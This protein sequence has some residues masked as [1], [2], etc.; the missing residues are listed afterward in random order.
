MSETFFSVLTY[1]PLVLHIVLPVEGFLFKKEKNEKKI[2]QIWLLFVCVCVCGITECHDHDYDD[3]NT[4]KRE[5][6]KKD[7]KNK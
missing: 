6:G 7:Q 3:K 4:D 1:N 5:H 2:M